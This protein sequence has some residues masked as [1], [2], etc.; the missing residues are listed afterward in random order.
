MRESNQNIFRKLTSVPMGNI[1]WMP[2]AC[3]FWLC[4][5]CANGGSL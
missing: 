5:S 4:C 1:L 3:A 2:D